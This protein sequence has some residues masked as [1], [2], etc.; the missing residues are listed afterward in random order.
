MPIRLRHSTAGTAATGPTDALVIDAPYVAVAT[1]ENTTSGSIQSGSYVSTQTVS[2]SEILVEQHSGGKP[3]NRKSYLNHTWTATGVVPGA[4]VGLEVVA[5]APSNS[6]NEDFIFTYSINGGPWQPL[7][8]L[9]SGSGQQT[10]SAALPAPTSGTVRINIVDSDPNTNGNRVTDTVTVHEITITSGG[11]VGD[12][13]PVVS[14]VSPADGTTVPVN[15][16]IEFVGT[17]IDDLDDNLSGSLSWSSDLVGDLSG[18][19]SSVATLSGGVHTVTASATD[20]ALQTGQDSITVT[21]S[22]TPLAAYMAISDLDGASAPAG[23]GNK[24]QATVTVTVQDDMGNPVSGATV[25]GSWS[26]GANGSGSCPTNAS[27]SCDISKGGLKSNA[28]SATFTVTGVSGGSLPYH[29]N[30]NQ[31]LDGDSTGTV[32]T[33]AAP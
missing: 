29:S 1:S 22:D 6:E 20:S 4:T 21:V 19:A 14:I 16:E 7:D 11:D 25:T 18:G 8:T 17:A 23:R 10:L 5:S 2:S 24:W 13:P 9:V 3:Q 12:Q 30:E 27:G 32:I 15:T 26:A 28:S 31:D 33:V